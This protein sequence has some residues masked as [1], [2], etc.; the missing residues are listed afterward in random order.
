[1]EDLTSTSQT[2]N[3]LDILPF[4]NMIETMINESHQEVLPK[5]PPCISP[6]PE[7]VPLAIA[8]SSWN[9]SSSDADAADE[10]IK[11]ILQKC[12]SLEDSQDYENLTKFLWSLPAKREIISALDQEEILLRAR[13]LVA[14]YQQNFREL[15]C[16]IETHEY[17]KDSHP[18]LQKLWLEAH[19][20]EAEKT[21]GRQLGPVDKYRV[22]KKYP[23][24]KSIWDG[25]N[26]SHCFKER[27]RSI[28][29]ESYLQEPYPCPNRKR[30][31]ATST[32]L[33]SVQVGNWFKN[34]RQRDRAA[35][36]K[37]RMPD[38]I[39]ASLNKFG[40]QAHK[41][42]MKDQ[43]EVSGIS[44]PS[45]NHRSGPLFQLAEQL[46]KLQ[47]GNIGNV[48]F[49]QN[50]LGQLQALNSTSKLS[51]PIQPINMNLD[52]ENQTKLTSFDSQTNYFSKKSDNNLTFKKGISEVDKE[53]DQNQSNVEKEDRSQ[54]KIKNDNGAGKKSSKNTTFGS[55]GFSSDGNSEGMLEAQVSKSR[56]ST[57]KKGSNYI[58]MPTSVKN[59]LPQNELLQNGFQW[60][61]Q[62]ILQSQAQ[63]QAQAQ[64]YIKLQQAHAQQMQVH[65][66]QQ[67]QPQ[68]QQSL[69]K[70]F[71]AELLNK[72][73]NNGPKAP[74]NGSNFPS[75]S[76]KF[77]IENLMGPKNVG[78]NTNN[79]NF[80]KQLFAL[81]SK[82]NGGH[83]EPNL[84][85]NVE[86]KDIIDVED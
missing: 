82:I 21:R 64:K 58:S 32:G 47:Q 51:G 49:P 3:S 81:Y 29:R 77:S 60:Q 17:N 27:T 13:C 40:A 62:N 33:T 34:R 11:K 84:N 65:I 63:A 31:L 15:Y 23:F 74:Q 57:P 44:M 10:E 42:L 12:Q 50:I 39:P 69:Q 16:L 59:V 80:K 67:D 22:R 61:L 5:H 35:A 85:L 55:S 37:N 72:L 18:L 73:K 1:M 6:I 86:E 24:P 43:S 38:M 76:Q 70:Q 28:L 83:V 36:A 4:K 7:Q 20:V 54:S 26:K 71:Q 25:E 66:A 46:K 41:A 9:Q 78:Q 2:S 30:A 68:D 45:Q 14:N 53:K 79:D 75:N 8:A 56:Q 52:Q 48:N 19:Y